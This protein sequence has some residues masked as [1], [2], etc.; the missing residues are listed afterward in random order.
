MA[1]DELTEKQE[2]FFKVIDRYI[3]ENGVS[4]T[5]QELAELTEEK[6]ING[7]NQKLEQIRAKGYVRIHPPRKKRN[8]LILKQPYKQMVLFDND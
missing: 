8:I 1:N 2:G 7:V 6:S 5:R 4:P 3:K